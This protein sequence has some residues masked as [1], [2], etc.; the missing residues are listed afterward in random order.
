M[1]SRQL[2]S[3]MAYFCTS[4]ITQIAFLPTGGAGTQFY[5]KRELIFRSEGL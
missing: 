4:V 3:P 5:R 2:F 1:G